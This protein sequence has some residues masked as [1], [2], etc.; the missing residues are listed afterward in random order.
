MKAIPTDIIALHEK[1]LSKANVSVSSH[2]FYM[3]WL[4]YFF[5]FCYCL[6]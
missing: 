1:E 5:D 2:V 6:K 3:K 4:Q